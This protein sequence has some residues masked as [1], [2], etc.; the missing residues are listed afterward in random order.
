MRIQCVCLLLVL[1][2]APVLSLDVEKKTMSIEERYDKFINQHISENMN[3][4]RCDAEI[5][6]SNISVDNKKCKPKNTFIQASIKAVKS[7]C[8][9]KGEPYKNM[10]RSLEKFHIIFC[11]LKK[12]K[13]KYPTCHYTGKLLK[14]KIIIACDN[15]PVDYDGDIDYFEN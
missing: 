6:K 15:F 1:L 4:K 3:F 12:Q 7:V 13:A 2:S 11:E 14:R 5:R 8:A 9:G 10:T